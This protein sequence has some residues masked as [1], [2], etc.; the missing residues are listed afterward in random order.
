MFTAI[1]NQLQKLVIHIRK[2]NPLS[3]NILLDRSREAGLPGPQNAQKETQVR[4]KWNQLLRVELHPKIKE[5]VPV[6]T[7]PHYMIMI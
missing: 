6:A 4:L 1:N 2:W 3:H 7:L 5:D